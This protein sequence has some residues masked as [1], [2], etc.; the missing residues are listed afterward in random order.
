MSIA[1]FTQLATLPIA[2]G[3]LD[4]VCFPT[5]PA[6]YGNLDTDFCG[7]G[8]RNLQTVREHGAKYSLCLS[9]ICALQ[10]HSRGHWRDRY[11][12]HRAVHIKIP[13]NNSLSSCLGDVDV[14]THDSVTASAIYQQMLNETAEQNVL[15]G[16]PILTVIDFVGGFTNRSHGS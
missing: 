10:P 9:R 6:N 15:Q 3:S 8:S 2:N 5:S 7:S 1:P 14:A 12:H 16:A 4:K 13:Q 11:H